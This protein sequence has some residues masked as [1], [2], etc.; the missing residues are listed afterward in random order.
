MQYYSHYIW[1]SGS[2][3]KDNPIS[4]VLQQVSRKNHHYL[5]ACVCD[6]RTAER[7]GAEDSIQLSSYFAECLTEWFHKQ[8]L[9]MILRRKISSHDIHKSLEQ[10]LEKIRQEMTEYCRQ[11]KR[12]DTYSVLGILL[13]EDYF[14]LFHRGDVVGYLFN[15][16][17]NRRKRKPLQEQAGRKL[18]LVEGNAQKRIGILLCT[19][20]FGSTISE[21]EMIRVLF[22]NELDDKRI[23]K[24]LRE[25]RQADISRGI[26][27]AAGAVFIRLE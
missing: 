25:I 6:G 24:H 9:E 11:K 5:L 3:E 19:R 1:E 7:D 21:E 15:R 8:F 14:C 10:E 26:S 22:E 2:E 23:E 27:T 12:E 18:M 13:C 16:K 17:F 4:V 20:E